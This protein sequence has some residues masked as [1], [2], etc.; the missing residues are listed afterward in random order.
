M[1]AAAQ[2]CCDS[3]ISLSSITADSPTAQIY[4]AR[5]PPVDI[6]LCTSGVNRFSDFLLWQCHKDTDIQIV[7]TLWSD[8]GRR[9]I[10][11]LPF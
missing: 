2:Q 8:F 9:D 7:D 5:N 10:F 4:T 3:N 1:R 11:F 6:L